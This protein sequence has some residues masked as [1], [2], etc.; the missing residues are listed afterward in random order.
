LVPLPEAVKLARK[1]FW[2]GW[3]IIA[4]MSVPL[5]L[6][7]LKS[8][9]YGTLDS[10]AVLFRPAAQAINAWIVK[11]YNTIPVLRAL[12]PY[13]P[14]PSIPPLLSAENLWFA[15]LLLIVA[16]GAL[17]RDSGRHLSQRIA[18]V[19][20][21][22]EEK[23]WERSLTGDLPKPDV[24]AIQIDLTARDQWYKRPFGIVLLAIISGAFLLLIGRLLNISE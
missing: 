22:A 8:L 15:L 18:A 23:R 10:D 24:L 5:A 7:P 6:W 16:C 17:M 21:R 13:L 19:R 12:W 1:Q 20:Q 11:L 9:Y 4:V 2:G 3:A 14:H